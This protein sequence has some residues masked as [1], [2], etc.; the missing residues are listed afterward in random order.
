MLNILN[1]KNQK[2]IKKTVKNEKIIIYYDDITCI[3]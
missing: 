2:Y 3:K 1:K